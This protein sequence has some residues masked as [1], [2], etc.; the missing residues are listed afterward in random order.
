MKTLKKKIINNSFTIL[1]LIVLLIL[2][3]SFI[4]INKMNKIPVPVE[5]EEQQIRTKTLPN[6]EI[7]IYRVL[8]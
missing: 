8:S 1:F 2:I 4:R 3:V 5:E 6:S 7:I